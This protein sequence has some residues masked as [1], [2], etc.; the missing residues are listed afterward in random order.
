MVAGRQ[1]ALENPMFSLPA[2][3]AP[4]AAILPDLKSQ[5]RPGQAS[6]GTGDK[7]FPGFWSRR[8]HLSGSTKQR[9]STGSRDA[10]KPVQV[11]R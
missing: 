4:R 7:Q 9:S 1:P 10:L 3:A 11:T 6:I 2:A 5:A 8:S